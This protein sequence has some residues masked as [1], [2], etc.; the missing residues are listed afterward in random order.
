VILVTG[1]TGTVGREVVAQLAAAGAPVRALVR[2]PGKAAAL[3]PAGVDLA[4]GDL[5]RPATLAAAL[6]G[7]EKVF[8]LSPAD[9]RQ[10]EQQGNVIL[11][12]R[13]AGVGHVVKM[14][15]LGAS[16]G[17]PVSLLRWHRQ[18]EKELEKSGVAYTHLRP[19][20]FMQ[21][22]LGMAAAIAAQGVVHAPMKDGRVSI[23]D[24][25]DIA[26]VAVGVLTRAGHE[27]KTYDVTGPEALS[28]ADMAGKISAAIDKQVTYVNVPFTEARRDLVGAGMPEWLADSLLGLYGLF[29]AGHGSLVTNVVA[30]VAKKQPRTFDEFAREHAAAFRG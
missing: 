18:T 7:V 16:T 11:A 21:N 22:M 6:Q 3:L 30:E 28:Y 24:A 19:H 25:R 10:V 27:G 9:P 20:F 12:A 8:L 17:S 1:A 15:A 26:A 14:S 5:D 29:G 13:R 2:D 23:V 4:P